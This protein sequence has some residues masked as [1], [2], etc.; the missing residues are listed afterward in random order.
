[1]FEGKHFKVFHEEIASAQGEPQLFEYVWRTDGAR[2]IA[3]NEDQVLI[4]RE[5]RHE[6]DDFDWRL[7]GGKVD[8]GESPEEAAR[9]E[10]REETGVSA[11]SW[12]FLWTSTADSTVRYKRHFFM[13]TG[14]EIGEAAPGSGENIANHWIQ[15]D[16]ACALALEGGIREEISALALLRLRERRTG[17]WI[18]VLRS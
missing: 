4:T 8:A 2:I 3:L 13:A 17:S 16:E 14:I 5:F 18:P 1:V 10:L 11:A 7:P 9:R 12:E 15:L 6:L